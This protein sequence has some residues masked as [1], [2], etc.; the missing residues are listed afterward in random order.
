MPCWDHTEKIARSVIMMDWAFSFVTIRNS[1]I[2]CYDS[3]G[4]QSGIML[5]LQC[6]NVSVIWV[7]PVT[8]KLIILYDFTQSHYS[9]LAKYEINNRERSICCASDMSADNVAS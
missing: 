2:L 7:E 4:R 3:V 5:S 6:P 8:H 1:I 9:F